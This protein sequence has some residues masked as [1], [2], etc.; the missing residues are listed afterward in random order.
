[1]NC[2]SILHAQEL[3]NMWILVATP[4]KQHIDIIRV[5]FF[6][7]STKKAARPVQVVYE[8]NYGDL[9]CGI[10]EIKLGGL[11]ARRT[12]RTWRWHA[13]QPVQVHEGN[14][15]ELPSRIDENQNQNKNKLCIPRTR[16]RLDVEMLLSQNECTNANDELPSRID[17]NW[18]KTNWRTWE[19]GELDRLK[20]A[21]TVLYEGSLT[22]CLRYRWE[23]GELG[24][25]DTLKYCSAIQVHGD[26]ASRWTVLHDW[27]ELNW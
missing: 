4:R 23:L 14:C 1:M 25:L 17:E 5:W 22:N 7:L 6:E 9:S 19:V 15:D 8:G 12:R 27:W 10:D 16:R 20:A 26:N 11:R 21:Q 24:E 18:T 2:L 13:A 3:D